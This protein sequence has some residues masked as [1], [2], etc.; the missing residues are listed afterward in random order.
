VEDV[1][2]VNFRNRVPAIVL[3]E[4]IDGEYQPARAEAAGTMFVM[5]EPSEFSIDPGDLLDE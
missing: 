1:K 5:K 4:L 2:R 3:H